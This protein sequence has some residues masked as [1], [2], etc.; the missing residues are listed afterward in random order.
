VIRRRFPDVLWSA[1][2]TTR[3]D[4]VTEFGCDGD[5]LTERRERFADEFFARMW[6]V[7]LGRIEER[8]ALLVG[9]PNDPDALGS[10]CGGAVALR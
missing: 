6:T 5:F 8:D 3:L 1:V 9:R 2:V 4:V 10:V 7:N